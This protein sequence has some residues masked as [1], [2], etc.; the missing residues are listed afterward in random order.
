[1][2]K[3]LSKSCAGLFD[4]DS[5]DESVDNWISETLNDFA[6]EGY[7]LE[8]C[9]ISTFKDKGDNCNQFNAIVNLIL[10]KETEDS[11]SLQ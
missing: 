8:S 1:M 2:K 7:K 11:T 4:I 10:S 9:S 6:K 3:Y 5:T